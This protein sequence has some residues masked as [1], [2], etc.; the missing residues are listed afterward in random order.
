MMCHEALS[1]NSRDA[2]F[3]AMA[4]VVQHQNRRRRWVHVRVRPLLQA[5]RLPDRRPG[6]DHGWGDPGVSASSPWLAK[7]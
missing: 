4:N 7:A 3:L 2:V 1:Q 6:E 5:R